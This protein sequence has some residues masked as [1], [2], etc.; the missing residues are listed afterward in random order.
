M[1]AL[2]PLAVWAAIVAG[3]AYLIGKVLQS[4]LA[5]RRVH[6]NGTMTWRDD[7][8]LANRAARK[9]RQ[10]AR[11]KLRDARVSEEEVWRQVPHGDD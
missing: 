3:P 5:P 11:R 1:E 6:P 7:D 10:R 8:T 4:I 2:I 9:R